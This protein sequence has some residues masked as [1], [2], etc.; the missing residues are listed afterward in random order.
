M[1]MV[2]ST[3]KCLD[4]STCILPKQ[5]QDPVSTKP[6]ITANAN[7]EAIHRLRLG[8]Q[9][10]YR[11]DHH[12]TATP[13]SRNPTST[14][15]GTPISKPATLAATGD[16]SF[17]SPVKPQAKLAT[18]RNPSCRCAIFMVCGGYPQPHLFDVFLEHVMPAAHP[19]VVHLPT[20]PPST[21][22]TLI[23]MQMPVVGSGPIT[24]PSMVQEQNFT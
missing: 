21:N 17:A 10:R 14:I 13:S 9:Q 18:A 11:V 3:I 8:T 6:E 12:A 15:R 19:E 5:A 4:F 2:A 1:I 20:R 23:A 7:E 16:H 24:T 22:S